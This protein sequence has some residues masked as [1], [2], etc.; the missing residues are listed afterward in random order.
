MIKKI[1]IQNI[2][3]IGVGTPNSII[4]FDLY[5]NKPLVFVAPNGFGKSSIA[6]AFKSLKSTR[7]D[8][9]KE[10]YYQANDSLIPQ[11]IISIEDGSGSVS[12]LVANNSTNSISSKFDHFVINNQVFAKAKKNRIGGNVIAS[13]KL[14]IPEIVLIN[15]IPENKVFSYSPA[16]EKIKVGNNGKA[17][18]NISNI[19]SSKRFIYE[20]S[21]YFAILGR[22]NG[23]REKARIN[24]FIID[25]NAQNG[26]KDYLL[27]W[28]ETN[29]LS[30]LN[31]AQ[32]LT[33]IKQIIDKYDFGFS[34][35]SE[36]YLAALQ[37]S[38]IYNAD[39][40]L[41]KKACKTSAYLLQ[42]QT[43]KELFESFNSTWKEFKPKEKD[44]S[45]IIQVPKVN[46]ISNGQRDVLCF[47][48]LL[49]KARFKLKKDYSILI[50]DE[51]FDY[52]DDANLIAAQYYV[53]KFI[54]EFKE[55]GKKIYPIILTHLN[56]YYFKNYAFSKQK[57][58][59]LDKRSATI[60]P[61]FRKILINRNDIS[62]KDDLAK[63]HLHFQPNDVNLRTEFIALSLK[64]TWG[65]S[66]LFK[67]FV[68]DEFTKYSL[69]QSDYDPFAVCCYIRKKIEEKIYSQISDPAHQVTFLS[70]YKTKE[71]LRFAESTGAN[72]PEV[73]YLLGIIYNDGLHYKN[74]EVAIAGKLEN[75]T[76][77]K[78][79][80]E[81]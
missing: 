54:Q 52:L 51:I 71:K 5:P 57:T 6:V 67:V 66:N 8:L 37:L 49:Q 78:M 72:V 13:A 19:L 35:E 39:S 74:N 11:I 64:E 60:N 45:L 65:E 28:I 80:T 41:F 29:K 47:I 3:G 44:G 61:H 36:T 21:N 23:E 9:N 58:F 53:T 68:D 12:Q 15:T 48:A 25:L 63:Y 40:V 31:Q 26:T 30:D 42:K 22:I 16:A 76:I 27:N 75:V 59:F 14:E 17:L 33:Q 56:P 32:N 62:I 24:S 4:E 7:I 50:V 34:R 46:Q 77:R 20:L 70:T 43:F 73:Y 1:E 18:S 38:S 79:I 81:I 2:K 55:E 69:N 10:H